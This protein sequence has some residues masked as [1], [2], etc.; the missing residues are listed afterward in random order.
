MQRVRI[1]IR[2]IPL[3][4]TRA[5][6]P[7]F[8]MEAVLVVFDFGD[9]VSAFAAAHQADRPDNVH[10]NRTTMVAT[11]IMIGSSAAHVGC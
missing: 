7:V 4:T 11:P 3:I 2:L 10:D 5:T 1:V 9:L 8:R 6:N